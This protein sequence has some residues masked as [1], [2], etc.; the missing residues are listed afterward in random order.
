MALKFHRKTV[1]IHVLLSQIV[2]V[3]VPF[4]V[5]AEE[6]PRDIEYVYPDQ[7]VWTTRIDANGVLANPL[8][9]FAE[10]LLS[11]MQLNWSAS[12]Y[13]AERMF[14]RLEQGKSNFSILVKAP[15]LAE[16]CVFSKK[17]VVFTELRVYRK[18]NM[19]AVKSKEDL[20]GKNL[21]V[22]RGYSY[23]GIGRYLRD[24]ATNVIIH[25][26]P[27]HDSAFEMLAFGR[28]EYLLDYAGPSG[29]VLALHPQP[30][31]AYDALERL[32]IYLVLSK[33][34]P[35]AEMM[36]EKLETVAS[37]IDVGQWGLQRP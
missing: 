9:H 32:N 30:G 2:A 24:P 5:C 31:V 12:P 26:A 34:Y 3:I 13:P 16:K 4:L 18:E 35:D 1:L 19:P 20:K 7:S 28:A 17:P 22:I 23:G 33:G 27:R 36:M 8:L 14:K 15:R 21:I 25:E 10:A 29:E 6:S 37:S 11:R